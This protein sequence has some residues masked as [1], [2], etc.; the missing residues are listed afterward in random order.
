[1]SRHE[2]VDR[3]ASDLPSAVPTAVAELL[4]AG[5]VMDPAIRPLWEPMPTVVGPAHVVRCAP[6]DNL[7]LHAA[8]YR[9]TPGSV[10]VVDSGG[11]APA[12]AGGNVCA[13]AQRRGSAG[14]VVDGNV[15]DLGEIRAMGYPVLARGVFPKPGVKRDPG[16]QGQAVVGGVLVRDGDVIVADVEGIVVVPAERGAEVL[17]AAAAKEA[18]EAEQGLDVWEANHRATVTAALEAAGDTTGLPD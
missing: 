16:S 6:G 18:R 17:A 1:M 9:A 15:R 5:Q 13:I 2:M 11:E 7:A 14:M 12:V 8:V 10:L 3:K 4:D